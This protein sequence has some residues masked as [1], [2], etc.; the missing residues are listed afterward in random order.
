MGMGVHVR[1]AVVGLAVCTLV[2]SAGSVAADQTMRRDGDDVR[3]FMDIAWV[4]HDHVRRADGT[5]RIRHII[6]MHDPWRSRLLRSACPT[7]QVFLDHLGRA[8][9]FYWD[10]GVKAKLGRRELPA[11]RPNRRSI[12]FRARPRLLA[13]ADRT[14]RWRARTLATATAPCEGGARGYEDFAPNERWIRH[15]LP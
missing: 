11:W 6:S 12:A 13:G 10:G 9:A 8:V 4:K 5:R 15:D 1:R 3:S 2:L 14:Y 7:I